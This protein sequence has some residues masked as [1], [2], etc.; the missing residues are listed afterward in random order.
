MS[1]DQLLVVALWL[2]CILGL[3]DFTIIALSRGE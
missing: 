3:V 2:I 1:E